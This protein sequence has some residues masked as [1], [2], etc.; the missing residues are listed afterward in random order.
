MTPAG[1]PVEHAGP[2]R[3]MAPTSPRWPKQH[4]IPRCCGG[5][6]R[7]P[8]SSQHHPIPPC[9]TY[10]HGAT[11]APDRLLARS[12][13]KILTPVRSPRSDY[14][15]AGLFF[16]SVFGYEHLFE[17]SGVA[18]G[19]GPDVSL[20]APGVALSGKTLDDLQTVLSR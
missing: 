13:P 6:H 5:I 2:T 10:R 4:G 8:A 16:G 7:T 15:S 3:L 11:I 17:Y 1:C 19:S 9:P 14:R 20:A 18:V 12:K